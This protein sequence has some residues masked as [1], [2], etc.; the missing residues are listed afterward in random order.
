MEP[1]NE[2][3]VQVTAYAMTA[4]EG[5]VFIMMFLSSADSFLI[6]LLSSIIW[7]FIVCF[8]YIH[9]IHVIHALFIAGTDYEFE[10][11]NVTIN[12]GATM[13][14]SPQCFNLTIR[15]DRILEDNET[16]LLLLDSSDSS[17]LDSSAMMVI[18]VIVDDDGM[19]VYVKYVSFH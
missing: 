10:A 7:G 5:I 4:Q 8:V 11:V 3:I 14:Q 12:M 15:G 6:F 1:A 18:V 9:F 13:D 2:T 16:F 17:F 19:S